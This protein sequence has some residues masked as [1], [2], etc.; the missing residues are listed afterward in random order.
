VVVSGLN[1]FLYTIPSPI[2]YLFREWSE[3]DFPKLLRYLF[4]EWSEADFP[5]PS[6]IGVSGNRT[7]FPSP[8]ILTLA[9][10][11]YIRRDWIVVVSGL[12]PFLHT[13]LVVINVLTPKG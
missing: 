4:R 6:N 7:S 3:A 1:P 10:V 11:L 5:K 13:I 2:G 8:Q 12:N 9:K